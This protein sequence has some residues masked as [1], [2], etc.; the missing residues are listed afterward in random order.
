MMDEINRAINLNFMEIAH[1]T[2]KYFDVLINMNHPTDCVKARSPI[3]MIPYF[4]ILILVSFIII[5]AIL[6]F[7]AELLV[8]YY[9]KN[10]VFYY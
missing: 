3:S 9:F 4:G 1:I 2:R 8:G 5:T 10:R 6:V 7:F